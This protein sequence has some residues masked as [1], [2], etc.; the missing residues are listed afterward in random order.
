[1]I[2]RIVLEIRLSKLRLAESNVRRTPAPAWAD[3]ELKASILAHGLLENLVVVDAADG[4]YEVVAGGRRLKLMRELADEGDMPSEAPIPC[5]VVDPSEAEEASLAENTARAGMHP[6]DQIEAF[7]RLAKAGATVE[8]IAA[9]FGA[10]DRL[11]RQRLRLA[12]LPV[13]IV[14][15]YRE[16]RIDMA[17]LEAFGS[18]SEPARALAAWKALEGRRGIWAGDVKAEL[19]G[20]G[21][22]RG[23]AKLARYVG[24]GAF[25]GAGGVVERDLFAGDDDDS[26]LVFG[27]GALLTRLAKEKLERG[28]KRHESKGWGWVECRLDFGWDARARYRQIYEQP[29]EP[30]KAEAGRLAKLDARF[31]ELHAVEDREAWRKVRDERAKITAAL[32][33]RG[34]FPPEHMAG[35]GVVCTIDHQGRAETHEGL[36]RPGDPVPREQAT[37]G[38][39]KIDQEAEARRKAGVPTGV[40]DD[41]RAVR[42]TLAKA[43]LVGNYSAAWD[44]AVFSLALDA[45][46]PTG[47]LGGVYHTALDA[48]LVP[49]ETR[50]PKRRNDD[51]AY[52]EWAKPA[53]DAWAEALEGIPRHW[54]DEGSV[55]ESW[56]A[57]QELPPWAKKRLFAGAV[58][59]TLRPQLSFEVSARPEVEATL[60]RLRLDFGQVKPTAEMFLGRLQKADLL[61]RCQEVLG[62]EWVADRKSLKKGDLAKAAA[63]AFAELDE[64]WILPGL[65]PG[66]AS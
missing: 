13:E 28:A 52:A 23:D 66:G 27:D 53:E 62:D 17:A 56:A 43:A 36:V 64:P 14:D 29:A 21:S 6:A 7:G 40:A 15:A 9:R 16:G 65:A 38:Q 42:T 19:M 51:G 39:R 26:G 11:V 8:A 3:A 59:R 24:V 50:P 45:F 22:V 48:R 37:P 58:A 30:T 55:A 35:A 12:D 46:G 61:A 5:Q 2:P 41:L 31:A 1:M 4:M 18:T 47:G 25:E 49:S 54:I 10:S 32:R 34:G 60:G 20:S 57:F 44:L 33:K 63:E